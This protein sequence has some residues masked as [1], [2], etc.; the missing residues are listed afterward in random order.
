MSK[1]KQSVKT[2]MN[3]KV[4]ASVSNNKGVKNIALNLKVP[5]NTRIKVKK[6]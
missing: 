6:S 4:K 2:P 5:R 3:S 1:I